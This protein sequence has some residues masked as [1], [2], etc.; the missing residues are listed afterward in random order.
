MYIG[1]VTAW[2]YLVLQIYFYKLA[3]SE[4]INNKLKRNLLMHRYT[5]K[6]KRN[7]AHGNRVIS[8]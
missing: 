8:I 4:A 5:M 1:W 2:E 3:Y 6:D 7:T